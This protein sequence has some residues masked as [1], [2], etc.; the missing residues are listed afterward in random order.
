MNYEN[1]IQKSKSD[2]TVEK[3]DSLKL[4]RIKR[5]LLLTQYMIPF[6]TPLEKVDPTVVVDIVAKDSK[7]NLA[8]PVE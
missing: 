1:T 6:D 3:Y 8:L 2:N 7:Y 4:K 5:L